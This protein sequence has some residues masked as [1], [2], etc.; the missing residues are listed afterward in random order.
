MVREALRS[1]SSSVSLALVNSSQGINAGAVEFYSSESTSTTLRPKLVLTYDPVSPFASAGPDQNL[2]NWSLGSRIT[3]DGSASSDA[4]TAQSSLK[5]SWGFA[6]KPGASNLTDSSITPN[7]TT[8]SAGASR[9]TFVPDTYGTYTI[10]VRV[11]NGAGAISED[12]V[13]VRVASYPA[14]HPRVFLTPERIAK[15]KTLVASNTY[16]WQHALKFASGSAYDAQKQFIKGK[17]L[18][19]VLKATSNYTTFGDSVV[20]QVMSKI[21]THIHDPLYSTYGIE[22]VA[23]GYDWCYDRFTATQRQQIIAWLNDEADYLKANYWGS[24]GWSNYYIRG[25][26]ANALAGYATYGENAAAQSHIDEANKRWKT[27]QAGFELTGVGGGWPEGTGYDGWQTVNLAEYAQLVKSATGED[28]FMSTPFFRDRLRYALFA[29]HP[30]FI[31]TG[32]NS[33]YAPY[34]RQTVLIGDGRRGVYGN[35]VEARI[36]C[37][38]LVDY[39]YGKDPA[40]QELQWFLT[41]APANHIAFDEYM[42]DEFMYFDPNRAKTMPTTMAHYAPGVG[43]AYFRSDWDA[44]EGATWLSFKSSGHYEGHQHLDANSFTIWKKGDL[45]T[46]SGEMDDDIGSDWSINYDRRTIA[47][48]SM[49]IYDPQ[50]KFKGFYQMKEGVNDGGQRTMDPTSLSSSVDMWMAYPY[51]FDKA[52]IT[53]Y[54]NTSSYGYAM[55]DATNAYNSPRY[56]TP[57]NRAKVTNYTRQMVYIRPTSLGGDDFVVVYDRVSS[58]DATFQKKWLLHT[59]T[60]PTVNGTETKI[61]NHEYVYNGDT[62]QV[63]AGKTGTSGDGDGRLFGKV[64]LP[65]A[66]RI[67]KIGGQANV[68]TIVAASTNK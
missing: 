33:N 45:A 14:A 29:N 63:D 58:T 49:L 23:Y 56:V 3:L 38:M 46:E 1:G 40:A 50:E 32:Y 51:I 64:L 4:S 7:N 34:A 8:G 47:H 24:S 43:E 13:D 19:Y 42:I 60:A 31:M 21:A 2:T 18:V 55:G 37:D 27:C 48:N 36:T 5:F 15:L 44:G 35:T 52:K 10:K 57:G 61:D 30:S 53:R 28:L 54:E 26:Y 16:E 20:T 25:M 17:G 22:V 59:L 62:F 11:T 6:K 39:F 41:Q 67:R 68:S 65:K 9:P 66:H 12:T